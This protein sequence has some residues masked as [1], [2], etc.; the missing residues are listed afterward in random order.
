MQ[1]PLPD[2]DVACVPLVIP[3]RVQIAVVFRERGGRD[4]DAQAMAGG[5]HPGCE[6]QIDVVLVDLAGLEERGAITESWAKLGELRSSGC[7]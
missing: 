4:D 2:H 5:D 1:N 6:P 3:A 7:I